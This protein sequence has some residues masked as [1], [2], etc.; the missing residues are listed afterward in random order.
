VAGALAGYDVEKL[1]QDSRHDRG[2]SIALHFW[3]DWIPTMMNPPIPF[4]D[5]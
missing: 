3:W 1:Y 5:A 4:E 2:R